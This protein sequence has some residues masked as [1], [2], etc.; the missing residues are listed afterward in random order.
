[1]QKD[2][3]SAVT[4]GS[5]KSLKRNKRKLKRSLTKSKKSNEFLEYKKLKIKNLSKAL[6]KV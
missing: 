2:F 6:L 3:Q 5:W 4:K 1:M